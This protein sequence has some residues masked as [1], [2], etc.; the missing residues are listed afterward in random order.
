M[1]NKFDHQLESLNT[2]LIKMGSLVEEAIEN[3]IQALEQNDIELA[4]KAILF[5]KEVDNMEKEIERYCL[6]LLLQ[7][8]PVA[9]DLRQISTALKMITD[10]ERIGDQAADIS[11]ITLKYEKQDYTN[12]MLHIPEMAKATVKMVHNSIDAFVKRDL[13]LVRSVIA[14]DD[15]VD[16]LF[17]TV[18]D[19]LIEFIRD[20]K[21]AGAQAMD[22]F[23]IAKYLE[24]IGDHATN[25]AECVLF[26]ITG[27]YKEK[28][29]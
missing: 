7:Q 27:V 18:R 17:V 24:R 2:N 23:M 5:D 6:K 13:N 22:L 4:K 14:D 21:T 8:Q 11:E 25:V 1:R 28:M 9:S 19:D 20:N 3:A 16:G 12:G 15:I 10:L 26:S 29:V